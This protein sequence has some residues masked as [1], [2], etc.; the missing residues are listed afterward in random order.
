VSENEVE[1]LTS[2]LRNNEVSESR[3]RKTSPVSEKRGSSSGS[4]LGPNRDAVQIIAKEVFT[5]I[6]GKGALYMYLF[7][8]IFY[9]AGTFH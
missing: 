8:P 2:G 9:V 7:V 1:N 4:N 6:G 3:H 5:M